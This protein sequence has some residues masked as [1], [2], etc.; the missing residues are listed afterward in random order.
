MAAMAETFRWKPLCG[1]LAAERSTRSKWLIHTCDGSMPSQMGSW[2]VMSSWA[3]PYSPCSPFRR[4]RQVMRHQLMAIADAEDWHA[5]IEQRGIDVGASGIVYA[6]RPAGNDHAA[7]GKQFRGRGFTRL[8]F[9]VNSQFAHAPAIRWV[10]WPPVS[11][12]VIWGAP[13]AVEPVMSRSEFVAD[14]LFEGASTI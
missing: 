13:I 7:T 2:A 8:N 12:T 4:Y 9:G 3:M 14:K 5:G 6:G 10:Y 11:R 1:N